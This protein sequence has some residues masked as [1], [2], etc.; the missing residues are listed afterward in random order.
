MGRLRLVSSFRAL[1]ALWSNILSTPRSLMSE[2]DKRLF[3]FLLSI[4]RPQRS[5]FLSSPSTTSAESMHA[6]DANN[7]LCLKTKLCLKNAV[8]LTNA[9]EKHRFEAHY[10]RIAGVWCGKRFHWLICNYIERFSLALHETLVIVCLSLGWR[11]L[12]RSAKCT[13]KFSIH[14][15]FQT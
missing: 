2:G 12:R 13:L 1:K 10:S 11:S 5:T 8:N 4:L 15:R 7:K 9:R 3:P 14:R 6:F